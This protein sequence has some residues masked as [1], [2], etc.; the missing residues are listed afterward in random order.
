MHVHSQNPT[1][2]GPV[3]PVPDV[4]GIIGKDPY[5]TELLPV[6]LRLRSQVPLQ[7]K[8]L[9]MSSITLNHIEN[10]NFHIRLL[11][12]NKYSAAQVFV[13]RHQKI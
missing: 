9:S 11:Q 6:I 13:L 7:E 5:L 4:H 8:D 10:N 12:G 1:W 3:L 2:A